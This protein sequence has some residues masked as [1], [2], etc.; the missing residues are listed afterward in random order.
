[1]FANAILCKNDANLRISFEIYATCVKKC[2][3]LRHEL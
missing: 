1:M 2:V 3:S